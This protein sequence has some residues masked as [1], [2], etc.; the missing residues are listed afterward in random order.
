MIIND[1]ATGQ[2]FPGNIIPSSRISPV[3]QRILQ[4][5]PD[6]NR[7]TDTGTGPLYQRNFRLTDLLLR[8]ET[9]N[10]DARVDHYF[11]PTQHTYVRFTYFDSPNGRS[12]FNLPGFGGNYFIV[13]NKIATV[14]HT[15]TFRPSLI[16]HIMVG[17]FNENDP[18]GPG[19]FESYDSATAWNQQLGITGIPAEQDSG[20]PYLTF[21]QTQLTTPLSWGFSNYQNRIW[22]I[23]DDV[24]W[25]RGKHNI[26]FGI[27]FRRDREGSDLPGVGQLNAGSCQ[28]GC[29]TF[30]G[31]W[32]GLDFGDF[33]LGLPFTSS[34]TIL[35][36]PDM[37]TR[38]EWAAYF[39]H[40]VGEPGRLSGGTAQGR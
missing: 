9:F 26:Q 20:F 19:K 28:Y 23:R 32:T 1:P 13:K 25:M 39:H 5:Y 12:Q 17:L 30:N 40:R 24:S 34:R 4:V 16:N 37:R 29:M 10:F 35:L 14:H 31:R 8:K 3:A 7:P 2:P 18:L 33:L 6:A 38:N 15:S 36:P 11:T 22:H 27:E 21:S